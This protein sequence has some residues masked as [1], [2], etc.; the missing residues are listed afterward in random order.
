MSRSSRSVPVRAAGSRFGDPAAI[1]VAFGAVVAG[2]GAVAAPVRTASMLL[3]AALFLLGLGLAGLIYVAVHYTTGAGWDVVVRRVAEAVAGLVPAGS[4]LALVA[5]IAG[6]RSLY[7]F[8]RAGETGAALHFGAFKAL[9]LAPPFFYGR[10]VVYTLVWSA[11]AL[12]LRG[13][14]RHQDA[15]DPDGRI[16]L[17]AT[18][19]SAAFLPV[20]AVTVSLASFDWV[21]ALEPHWYSTMFGVYQFA[22][23]FVSGIAAVVLLVIRLRR[24]GVLLGAVKEE[25]LHDLGKLLFAMSTFWAYIWFSQYLLVWYGNLAEEAS[26]FVPRTEGAWAPLF[27]AVPVL[28]WAVPFLALLPARAKH[29]ERILVQM[30]VL[31]LVGHLLDLYLAVQPSLFP[32]GPLFGGW[33][34]GLLLG[35]AALGWLVLRRALAGAPAVPAGDPLLEESLH[36]H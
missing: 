11:F 9:W 5:V 14:S 27:W 24:A 13:L 12:V 19:W 4:L 36:H 7:P 21:M 20:F 2:A 28:L 33:E 32:A 18:R 1:L 17:R 22:G 26:Y 15:G 31:I 29:D 25:H 34:A 3:V 30:S 16:R 10:A 8:L 6:G 23:L 35:G